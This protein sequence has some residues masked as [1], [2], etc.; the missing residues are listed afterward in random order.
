MQI[1]QPKIYL[2]DT[3]EVYNSYTGECI[4]K[5]LVVK[6]TPQSGEDVL[7]WFFF[8]PEKSRLIATGAEVFVI[9]QYN[10]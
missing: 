6:Q 2:E 3:V 5:E 1:E 9:K 10:R 7:H 4:G 8:D